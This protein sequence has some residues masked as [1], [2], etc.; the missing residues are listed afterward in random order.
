MKILMKM[1]NL[2]MIV[3]IS[4]CHC[5]NIILEQTKKVILYFFSFWPF[6]DVLKLV[7]PDGRSLQ[8]LL[9]HDLQVWVET[10]SCFSFKNLRNK[11]DDVALSFN[12]N[13]II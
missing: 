2:V 1:F 3:Q 6:W 8:Q 9:D 11:V 4:D 13:L 7:G 10:D 5:R 12:G